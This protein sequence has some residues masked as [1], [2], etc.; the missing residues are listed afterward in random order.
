ML[1]V[2][3]DAIVNFKSYMAE[4]NITSALRVAV[5]DGG[6]SG[7][8]LGLALDEKKNT[9]KLFTIDAIDF[10]V[11]EELFTKTG[12]IKVDYIDTEGSKGFAISSENKIGGGGCSSCSSCG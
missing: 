12:A 5:M 4:N 1:T 11:D 7:P 3:N 2:T 10:L 9:D 6:C 8:S